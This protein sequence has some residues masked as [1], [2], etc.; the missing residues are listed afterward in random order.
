MKFN[1][2]K[3]KKFFYLEKN[4]FKKVIIFHI[5]QFLY[6]KVFWIFLFLI[7]T[8]PIIVLVPIIKATDLYANSYLFALIVVFSMIFF[9]FYLVFK[10]FSN[11]SNNFVDETLIT[12]GFDKKTIYITRILIIYTLIFTCCFFQ[13]ILSVIITTSTEW[14]KLT[15]N[16]WLIM[17]FGQIISTMIFVPIFIYVSS[18]KC[19]I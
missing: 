13:S 10:L 18:S 3:L 12:K 16:V 17:F 8:L 19:N 14:Y 15:L 11:N 9:I 2:D 7:L 5:K 6:S 4:D 1:S